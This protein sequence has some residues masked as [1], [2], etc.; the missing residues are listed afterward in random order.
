MN[1]NNI[2]FLILFLLIGIVIYI[3]F[4]KTDLINRNDINNSNQSDFKTSV[5]SEFR[6]E[7][8]YVGNSRWEYTVTGQ[9]PN[10]CYNAEVDS[11]V[12]ESYPE[13]VTVTVTIQE[14]KADMICTQV[15]QDFKYNGTFSAS[16]KAEI[17][18]SVK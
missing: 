18:L 13:Q 10:P 2:L 12:A 11:I 3:L 7:S 6:L 9:L 1:R 8:R 15:I 5:Q 4:I 17:T 14:P 16:E